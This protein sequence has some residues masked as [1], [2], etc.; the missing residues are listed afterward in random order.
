M[1]IEDASGNVHPREDKRKRKKKKWGEETSNRERGVERG[2]AFVLFS[3]IYLFQNS[4]LFLFFL[5]LFLSR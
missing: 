1:P 5:F 2:H 4:L 3:F